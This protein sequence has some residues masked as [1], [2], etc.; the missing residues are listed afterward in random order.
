MSLPDSINYQVAFDEGE[1]AHCVEGRLLSDSEELELRLLDGHWAR[2][3]Y[4]KKKH[5]KRGAELTL[6]LADGWEART[7]LVPGMQLRWPEDAA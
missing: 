1:L 3:I 2:A 5:T 6:L 4:N 7:T